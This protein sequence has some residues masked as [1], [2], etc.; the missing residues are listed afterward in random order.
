MQRIEDEEAY[1]K[2]FQEHDGLGSLLGS[3]LIS[4]SAEE[5]LSEYEAKPE[6]YNPNGILHGG[7]LYTVMDSAQGAFVHYF[8]EDTFQAAATGTATIKYFEPVR[9]G[10]ITIRTHLKQRQG[11]KIFVFSSAKNEEGR[12]VA[13]LEEVW[14]A[15]LK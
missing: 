6:H 4:V 3:R 5:C 2:W 13:A 15:I 8:L 11:R 9:G 1:R 12:E 7:A 14:I 10:K